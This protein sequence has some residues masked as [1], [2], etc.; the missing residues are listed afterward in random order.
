MPLFHGVEPATLAA[1]E[2][3][4]VRHHLEAGSWLFREG[5]PADGL[6]VVVSGRLRVVVAG[7]DE[8]RVVRELG[9]GSALGELALLTGSARSAGAQA[10]RDCELLEV[11][12]S[13][14]TA[15]LDEDPGFSRA[16]A[17]ELARQLQASGGLE[18]PTVR[19]RV[20]SIVPLAPEV[21][22][23]RFATSFERELRRYG[24]VAVLDSGG[25]A[26]DRAAALARAEAAVDFVLLVAGPGSEAGSWDAFARRQADRVL[27]L[28]DSDTPIGTHGG[29]CDLVL[30]APLPRGAAAQWLDAVTPSTHHLVYEAAYDIGV[31]RVARRV[32][33]RS[34][35]LVLSGGGARGYAHIGVITA[36][37]EAGFEIDRLGGCSMGAYIAAMSALGLDTDQIHDRCHDELVRRTPFNDWTLPRVAL[38]RSRKAARMLERVFGDLQVEELPRSLFTV[39][40]DLLSSRVVVHRRGSLIDAVGVSMSI[41]GLVPPVARGGRLLVD[42]G[43][44]NNLPVDLMHDIPEGPI[45]AVDVVRRLESRPGQAVRI[46]SIMET[47][48]RATVLGSV[49]RAEMNRGLATLTISPEVQDIGLREFKALDRAIAAG[50]AAATAA[51][52]DGGADV[53]REALR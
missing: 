23:A 16:V 29:D 53:L 11:G 28:A 33:G 9:P 10:V 14:V 15:H 2:R 32:A 30:L 20:F 47:L 25:T 43:V 21:D 36:L 35:G 13:T 19:P 51:L 5:D 48:S 49:E 31:A 34:L 52:A 44:L 12:R 45:V 27:F 26:G 18:T 4:A 17:V 7:D 3:D 41:P 40:A 46:P 6:F 8:S 39:S 37:A 24:T 1:L 50:H 38:I 42:G 22:A